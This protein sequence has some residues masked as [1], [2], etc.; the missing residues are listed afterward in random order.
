[1][2]TVTHDWNTECLLL[3][4]SDWITGTFPGHHDSADFPSAK[5]S[6]TQD[7]RLLP[8][9][10]LLTTPAPASIAAVMCH[11]RVGDRHGLDFIARGLF[12]TFRDHGDEL[13]ISS[14]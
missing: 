4:I 10:S 2:F 6:S 8:T 12:K 9:E 1:M 3:C 5:L 7:R 14:A 13:H 11:N